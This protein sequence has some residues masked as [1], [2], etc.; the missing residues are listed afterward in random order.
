MKIVFSEECRKWIHS[1]V[2]DDYGFEPE[3]IDVD[4]DS[5]DKGM[6]LKAK[7]EELKG[8][9]EILPETFEELCGLQVNVLKKRLELII[10]VEQ[11]MKHLMAVLDPDQY[12]NRKRSEWTL[13]PLL[14]NGF[15]I[16]PQDYNLSYDISSVNFRHK[17]CYI[18]VYRIRNE[19][20]HAFESLNRKEIERLVT[21]F[22]IVYLDISRK[23]RNEI[24]RA[25]MKQKV[26]L[27]F[28]EVEYCKKIVEE[29]RDRVRNG[30][31]YV[32]IKWKADKEDAAEYSTVDTILFDG[33][34]QTVKI[35]GEAGCGKT[36]IMRQMEY[37]LAEKVVE[38]KSD[39]IPV[40][41]PLNIVEYN[42]D[43]A[44]NIETMISDQLNTSSTT[45]QELLKNNKLV[46]FLDA[47]NEILDLKTKKKMA[48]SID[49]LIRSYPG[50][51]V[52][53]TDRALVRSAINTMKTA[54]VYKLYPL[55]DELK[56]KYIQ[57]NCADQK[58]K[59]LLIDHFREH[60]DEYRKFDTPMRLKQLVEI[61]I[62]K[63]EIPKDIDGEYLRYLLN[64]EVYEKNDENAEYLEVFA[65]GL[66]LEEDE[67]TE[68]DAEAC[69]ARC[70][71]VLGYS[72]PDSR[73]CLRL[74]IEIGILD[75]ENGYIRFKYQSYKEYFWA[76]ALEKN[77]DTVLNIEG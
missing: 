36:T 31:S 39:I 30:F 22:L 65:A 41:I 35:L 70:K 48:S 24:D 46:L 68:Y 19:S 59:E 1:Y 7:V 42:G 50:N 4:I 53:L 55:D 66:A 15:N 26:N 23:K 64:R 47:F 52:F 54:L 51:C 77:L 76:A 9:N 67:L 58:V 34:S 61:T 3:E 33:T 25:Y 72:I 16:V 74:L 38:R 11:Y 14:K 17:W 20:S 73:Q 40:F 2:D 32:D 28:S 12:A 6:Q 71:N 18:E 45:T 56:E 75:V 60:P 8:I 62:H 27:S 57:T 13:A 63:K 29:N 21:A 69:I 44:G 37:L 49:N 5:F 10:K 43:A